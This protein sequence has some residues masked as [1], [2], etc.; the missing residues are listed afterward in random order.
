MSQEPELKLFTIFFLRLSSI[1]LGR[2][3]LCSGHFDDRQPVYSSGLA[4]CFR[5]SGQRFL[6]S[7]LP[8]L[9]DMAGAFTVVALLAAMGGSWAVHA[10]QYSRIAAL[11]YSR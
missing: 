9:L 5:H 6:R 4:V 11:M 2:P 3:G 1:D 7:G 8:M 10:D